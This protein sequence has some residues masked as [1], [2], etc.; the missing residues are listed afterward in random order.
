MNEPQTKKSI[1][2][3]VDV[4]GFRQFIQS[5]AAEP[6]QAREL[7]KALLAVKKIR[8]SESS[9]KGS[10]LTAILGSASSRC[11]GFTAFS[12]SV[13]ISNPLPELDIVNSTKPS[14]QVLS[15]IAVID[16][17]AEVAITFLGKGLLCRGGIAIGE[18]YHQNDVLFGGGLVDAYDLETGVA[19]YPRIVLNTNVISLLKTWSH[20]EVEGEAIPKRKTEPPWVT[21]KRDHDGIWFIDILLKMDLDDSSGFKQKFFA[22][23]D[24]VK[25]NLV[26]LQ[27][28][29]NLRMRAKW[30]WFANQINSVLA[31]P[32]FARDPCYSDMIKAE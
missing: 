19:V 7:I 15:A 9:K 8:S 29:N 27:T 13:V 32:P 20:D 25:S 5:T 12:D 24:L 16:A 10:G 21:L 22:V 11:S 18:M 2:A 26:G 4:L 17:A 23:H 14:N 28:T 3:F 30:L 6:Q 31:N 1:V